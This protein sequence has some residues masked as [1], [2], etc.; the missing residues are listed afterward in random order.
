MKDIR[1]P[2]AGNRIVDTFLPILETWLKDKTKVLKFG[3][4]LHKVAI[5]ERTAIC[6]M[7]DAGDYTAQQT[8]Q[9]CDAWGRQCRDLMQ[10]VGTDLTL[11]NFVKQMLGSE[12]AWRGAVFFCEQVMLWKELP[13]RLREDDPAADTVRQKRR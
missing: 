4:F 12:E 8:L 3:H 11:P 10:I 2:E 6:H 5:R 13:E 7:C 9:S 1:A